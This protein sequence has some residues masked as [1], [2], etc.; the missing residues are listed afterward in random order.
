MNNNIN[1]SE[2]TLRDLKEYEYDVNKMSI[3]FTSII[4]LINNKLDYIKLCIESIR[5]FTQK[6]KYEIIVVDNGLLCDDKWLGLQN[7]L[8]IIRVKYNLGISGMLNQGIDL[9]K[10]DN[11]IFL[12]DDVIVTPNWLYNLDSALNSSSNTG[13]VGAIANEGSILLEKDLS[14]NNLLEMLEFSKVYNL[15]N[16]ALWDYKIKLDTFCYMIKKEVL[17]KIGR[18]DD[19]FT[20]AEYACNDISL[21][22]LDYGYSLL[23]CKDTFVHNFNKIDNNKEF[24]KE[25][26]ANYNKL[27]LKWGYDI[28]YSSYIREEII[29]MIN[30]NAEEKIRVLEVGCGVGVTLLEIKNIYRNA[31]IYGIEIDK[32][33]GKICEKIFDKTI[34]NIEDMKDLKYGD[35]FFDYIIFADV[36]EHLKD[37]WNTL[38]KIKTYLKDDGNI[39]A[40]IPNIMHISVISDLI[41]GSFSYQPSGILDRT[42]LRFF[43]F[44]EIKKL[45]FKTGYDMD[46]IY[47]NEL[48]LTPENDDLIKKLKNISNIKNEKEYSASQYFLKASKK[49]Y[50]GIES[51]LEKYMEYSEYIHNKNEFLP[52]YEECLGEEYKPDSKDSKL[53]AYYLPQFHFNDDNNRWWGRGST[54]WDNVTRAVPQYM[55]HYQP[56]LP[57]D[58]GF[59]NL[60][61]LDSFNR[62][63]EL[64][65]KNGI[66]GF[67]MYYYFSGENKLLRRPLD[68][69]LENKELDIPFS[70]YWANEDWTKGY[71]SYSKEILVKQFDSVN[72]YKMAIND[73]EKYLR[74]ERYIKINNKKLIMIYR[75]LKIPNVSEVIEYWRN[76]C[77]V[78]GIGEIYV[79]ATKDRKCEDD[80]SLA[81]ADYYINCGFDGVNQFNPTADIEKFSLLNNKINFIRDDFSGEVFDHKQY[82]EQRKYVNTDYY[83]I[84]KCVFPSWDNT[85]RKGKDSW[86]FEGSS[87]KLY[88]KWIYD[89]M[90]TNK[91]NNY[92]DDDVVFINA[93]NEWGEGAIL[94]PC[95]KYGYAFLNATKKAIMDLRKNL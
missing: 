47:Y 42:H 72:E 54:E 87:P 79:M 18:F 58:M 67:S 55:G 73:M 20:L 85:P 53:I 23:L 37:P 38:V 76:Y 75:P 59:Y 46:T 24:L 26:K 41:K 80:S 32:N 61:M 63:I 49:E 84:Y 93:W 34:G 39:L 5:K 17:D 13:A 56:R 27:S 8:K 83:K 95:T 60:E 45:F 30:N 22:I 35:K 48:K 66:Y 78:N 57:I 94:E 69:L 51:K 10:G 70:L 90:L 1:L 86:I 71:K 7:D 64:A 33:S 19:L 92:L 25:S 21:K 44:D 88:Y 9:A 4:I 62:Q 11:I 12:K 68:I 82:V 65:K 6:D 2:D 43:T 3:R 31:E 74:D 15:L 91:G 50:T 36:L 40:S 89:T 14:Y 29:N 81:C 16:D 77:R 28:S 52:E